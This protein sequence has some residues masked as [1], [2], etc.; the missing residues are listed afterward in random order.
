MTD[1]AKRISSVAL[2]VF[3]LI[4]AC[5]THSWVYAR[6]GCID[7]TAVESTS[8]CLVAV[9]GDAIRNATVWPL[10]WT[11]ELSYQIIKAT[12]DTVR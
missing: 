9:Q 10:Y 1:R 5:F 6:Y 2:I 7:K 4:G 11:S 12:T 3:Y 8:N